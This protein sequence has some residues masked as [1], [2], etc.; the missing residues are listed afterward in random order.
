MYH[1]VDW[2]L[3]VAA[4]MT[5]VDKRA[6][7][8]TLFNF[9]HNVCTL[10]NDIF[11]IGKKAWVYGKQ[12]DQAEL[13]KLLL[14]LRLNLDF[15][16]ALFDV[17]PE[18]IQYENKRKLIGP[19]GRYESGFYSDAQAIARK[20]KLTGETLDPLAPEPARSFIGKKPE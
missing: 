18:L 8:I 14:V 16:Y 2:K 1:S 5:T 7:D 12:P 10:C 4:H 17:T 20:D 11:D 6:K 9:H 15:A 13:A 3:D 19:G